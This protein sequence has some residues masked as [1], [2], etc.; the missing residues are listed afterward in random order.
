MFLATLLFAAAALAT[1]SEE[2]VQEAESYLQKGEMQ[3]AVIQLKN[4]LQQDPDNARARFRL[5]ETYLELGQGA[6]AAKELGQAKALGVA[7]E[8]VLVPLGRALLMQGAHQRVLDEIEPPKDASAVLEAEIFVLHGQAE[9]ALGRVPEAKDKFE[10]AHQ[11]HADSSDVQLGLARIALVERDYDGATPYVAQALELD[12]KNVDAWL[13]KGEVARLQGDLAGARDAF[14]EALDIVPD[15]VL[16]RLGRATVQIGLEAHDSAAEDVA[17]VIERYPEAP[18][19]NHLQAVLAYHNRDMTGTEEALQKVLQVTPGHLPSMLL[20]GASLYAQ[21]KFEQ[22]L[23]PLDRYVAAIPNNPAARKLLGATHL[24]LGQPRE[25][26]AVLEADVD[27]AEGDAQ[28]LALLGSAYSQ[29]GDADKATEWLDKAVTLSP[30]A[31]A[32]RNQ[33][34]ISHLRQ[35]EAAQAVSELESAVDLGQGVFESDVL[36]ILA[37]LRNQ[38]LD[39]ALEAA[40][41]LVEKLPENPMP[42]NLLGAVYGAQ[43]DFNAARSQ[44]EK[45]LSLSPE[46]H[47]AAIN[48][49][50]LDV[51]A[52]QFDQA[53]E[54]LQSILSK[55]E[56]HTGAML[57]LAEV[58]MRQG[59]QEDIERWLERAREANPTAVQPGLVLARY[60]WQRGDHLE[61]AGIARELQRAHPK[62]LQVL[63]LLGSVRMAM[64]EHASAAENFQQAVDLQPQSPKYLWLLANAQAATKRYDAAADSLEQALSLQSDYLPAQMALG[65]LKQRIDLPQEALEIARQVQADHAQ[66]S[67]GY[68]LEGDIHMAAKEYGKAVGSYASG[69]DRQKT[70]E[71]AI[72]LFQARRQ[73]GNEAS[74]LDPME[75]WVA[76]HPEDLGV[77]QVLAQIYLQSSQTDAAIEQYRAVVE[78]QPD[79]V[80]ALNNLAWLYH[81][82]NDPRAVESAQRAYELAP[83]RPEIADTLGWLLLE[84]GNLERGLVLLQEAAGKAPHIPAIRYHRAVALAKN[85][86]GEEARKEIE[87][88]LRDHSGFAE[89]ADARSLLTQLTDQQ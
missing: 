13:V 88:L 75:D 85:N 25:A 23:P 24:R 49:A 56:A 58:A 79:N 82:Q 53:A 62:N 33:L 45:A 34:A 27:R 42:Y 61:A 80:V 18:A 7:A 29:A 12:P 40:Q 16:A 20:L 63:E 2:Y 54:R 41:A 65:R 67:Q 39:Q 64:G 43:Q 72:K 87:R 9:L 74:A 17:M 38:Q 3:A 10:K 48:L 57:A 15:N 83:D 86:R 22:A 71:L 77:R 21:G 89:E 52:G 76:Q 1:T 31:A 30:D 73:A 81:T 11:L 5:G 70:G 46:Y 69:W 78:G 51:A 84:S 19:A 37:H 14:S 28:W 66:N 4:A 55:D 68:V 6:A 26:I 35:G 47:A 36:L 50:R 60:H 44:F 8:Q 59:R 32:L